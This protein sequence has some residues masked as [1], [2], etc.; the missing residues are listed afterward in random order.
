MEMTSPGPTIYSGSPYFSVKTLFSLALLICLIASVIS[1]CCLSA[2]SKTAAGSRYVFTEMPV[3]SW[4]QDCIEIIMEIIRISKESDRIA[5]KIIMAPR[6]VDEQSSKRSIKL[7]I[8]LAFLENPY[9]C[10]ERIKYMKV[11][12]NRFLSS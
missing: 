9:Y 10:Q 8:G 12:I 5:L 2:V 1:C 4:A 6:N 11:K 7:Q 3:A